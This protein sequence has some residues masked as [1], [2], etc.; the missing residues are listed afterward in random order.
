MRARRLTTA[1]AAALVAAGAL[2][3]P[4]AASHGYDVDC[5]DF[6]YQQDAQAHLDDHPDDPDQLDTDGD[7]VACESLP[8]RPGT[9]TPTPTPAPGVPRP[10]AEP[11]DIAPACPPGVVGEDGFTDVPATNPFETAVDCVRHWQVANGWTTTTYAPADP[12]TREQMAAFIAR[13]IQYTGGTLPAAPPNAFTDDDGSNF[14]ADIDQLAAAEVVRGTSTTTFSP[15]QLVTRAQMAAFLVR[16]YD[17]RADQAGLAPLAPG[18]DYFPDDDGSTHRD[19]IDTAAA[20]GF[21]AGGTDGTYRPGDPVRRDHMAAFLSRVLAATVEAGMATVPSA[22]GTDGGTPAPTGSTDGTTDGGVTTAAHLLAELPLAPESGE[23]YDRD[24]LFGGWTDDDGD[25]CDTRSEVLQRD[26]EVAVTFGSGCTVAT[27]RWTSPYDGAMWTLASD[28]DIDHVVPLAEA[29][30]SGIR[31]DGWPASRRVAYANDLG[32]D[33][34]LLAVTDNVNQSKG[35]RDPAE[36]LPPSPEA[37]CTYAVQWVS[38]KHRWDLSVDT[39]EQSA[40]TSLLDTC[41]PVPVAVPPRP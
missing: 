19:D 16:A 40:L 15:R 5:G 32:Y 23:G 27:G 31:A 4:A 33:W 22:P 25:G 29:W 14:A 26:S 35:D 3:S 39:S 24:A 9:P 38:V 10:V 13:L 28:V 36:W 20:A 30:A 7:G 34:S 37:R 6:S 41:E 11:R 18:G 8:S 1:A 12:V 17:Y 2:T 21:A